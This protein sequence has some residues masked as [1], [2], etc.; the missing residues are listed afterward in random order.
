M[1]LV[2]W[3]DGYYDTPTDVPDQT[4]SGAEVVPMA[5]VKLEDLREVVEGLNKQYRGE[6]CFVY[7]EAFNDL[8]AQLEARRKE[9]GTGGG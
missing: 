6:A 1:S 2:K 5:V 3:V 7:A 4:V 8:L 9:A